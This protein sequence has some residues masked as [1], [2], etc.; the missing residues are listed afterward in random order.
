[1]ILRAST[2]FAPLDMLRDDGAGERFVGLGNNPARA[3]I[4]LVANRTYVMQ[5]AATAGD[6]QLNLRDARPGEW[7]S[8][9]LP[10]AS[11]PSKI[12]R[13]YWSG[14][15]MEAAGSLAAVQAGDGSLY[16]YDA[17]QGRIHL[18]LVVQPDRDWAHLRL[19]P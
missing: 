12:V 4:S 9:D 15:P 17:A 2:D 19:Y 7:I 3:S 5:T 8:V 11:A 16:W 10:L 1:L 13:D 14:H 6:M 18:R